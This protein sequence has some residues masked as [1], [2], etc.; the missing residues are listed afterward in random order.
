M[1]PVKHA[2][3]VIIGGGVAGCSIAYHLTKIGITDI[4][5]CER[6][7]LTCGTTW[8]AAGLV[9]QLRATRNM[10]ELAKYTGELFAG[11][12]AETGQAIGFKQNGAIRIAQ[13]EA[14]LEE[15]SRGVSMARNFGLTAHVIRP[16]EVAERWPGVKT[17]DLVGAI[18]MPNDGQVNPADVTMALAKGARARGAEIREDTPVRR[19]L[20]ENGRVTGV[21]LDG[22]A[23][24]ADKV[25]IAGGMWSRDF[26]AQIGVSLPLHAAE[27]FYIVTEPIPELKRDLPVMFS[28]DESA[29]YKE[30]AGKLLLGCFEPE[31]KPWGMDGIPEDFCFD[32]LPED[33]EHFEPILAQ[34]VERVPMLAQAGIQLFFN[35][36]ESFTP[37]DRYLLG[38]TPEVRNLFCACGFN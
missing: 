23:I 15:L 28:Y 19:V 12:E 4:V 37:D 17:D 21:E 29:Y 34:A 22:E 13:N 32:A 8:H 36:P 3:V 27:H 35:G 33:V 26:A 38:E 5:L 2:D 6:R 30:D 18:W 24:R 14:R 1:M 9:T 10:T 25:V 16:E 31:A 11:L 20:V 7:R